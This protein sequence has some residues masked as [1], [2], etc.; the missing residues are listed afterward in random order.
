MNSTH[1]TTGATDAGG[2]NRRN[3]AGEE[4]GATEAPA[5]Q[6]RVQSL[7][8][9][10]DRTFSEAPAVAA[11]SAALRF[12]GLRIAGDP[13]AL[14]MTDVSRL[15]T[16]GAVVPIPSPSPTLLGI[17]SLRNSLVA[18][19]DLHVLLGY[20]AGGSRRFWVL[21]RPGHPVGLAFDGL[22]G[23]FEADP[24]S[25]IEAAAGAARHTR[26]ATRSG[27][28]IRPII[29]VASILGALAGTTRENDTSAVER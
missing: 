4:P 19:H 12:L 25:P 26:G 6:A 29:D 27:A 1:G 14:R 28:S 3:V 15:H 5:W 23:H 20:P 22:D 9:A 21:V 10:F 13:F 7:R 18:V 17:A 2:V 11:A 24:N 16:G 8:E